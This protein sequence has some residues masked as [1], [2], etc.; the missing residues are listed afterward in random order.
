MSVKRTYEE[1]QTE[2]LGFDIK[3]VKI[4]PVDCYESD[5]LN[6]CLN[7]NRSADYCT[8]PIKQE[9]IGWD[10]TLWNQTPSAYMNY[11]YRDKFYSYDNIYSTEI[12]DNWQQLYGGYNMTEVLSFDSHD[13]FLE[14]D[15][16]L[17]SLEFE[18]PIQDA[19][20]PEVTEI[21]VITSQKRKRGTGT[22]RTNGGK[23]TTSASQYTTVPL[24]PCKVCSGVATGFHFGV[25][26]CEACKVI[27][28]KCY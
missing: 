11:M 14:S 24:P 13:F 26:T 10:E 2:I 7:L 17:Q 20:V 25:I 15:I 23:R 16:D 19:V 27:A 1:D 3:R 8:S 12:P 21:E 28:T 22:K 9:P 6:H 4:E 18:I 5:A